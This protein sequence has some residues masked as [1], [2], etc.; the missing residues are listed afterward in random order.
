MLDITEI[1]KFLPH[2]YPFLLVDRVIEIVAYER[3][4]AIKNVT[5]NEHFFMGHFP[6]E[7]IM[8]GVLILEAL[9]QTGG[10]LYLNSL[11][12]FNCEKIY[13]MALDKVKFR[14]IVGPGDQLRMELSVIQ[15]SRR[16][17]KMKGEAYVQERLV[18]EGE[19]L[20]SIFGGKD[21]K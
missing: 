21:N 14:K 4:V 10:I 18:T 5:Y 9:A 12:T 20:A 17:W 7:P 8:P 15:K 1:L 3:I 16:G 13:L 6:A 2:R 19:F 11:E